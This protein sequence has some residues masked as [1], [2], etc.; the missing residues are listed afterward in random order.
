[1]PVGFNGFRSIPSK[2]R[3][4]G[5][6]V[7][8]TQ[9][10]K[11]SF[12]SRTGEVVFNATALATYLNNGGNADGGYT[13]T[14]YVDNKKLNTKK[15]DARIDNFANTSKL[16][17]TGLRKSQA[18]RKK[19]YCQVDYLPFRGEGKCINAPLNSNV[20]YSV[21]GVVQPR[22]TFDTFDSEEPEI[23]SGIE[24]VFVDI[25][26]ELDITVQPEDQIVASGNT[27]VFDINSDFS[28]Q[29]I[30]Q[31]VSYQWQLGGVDLEDGE[32]E[33]SKLIPV[34]SRPTFTV[35]SD[36]EDSFTIDWSELTS[37]NTFTPGVTY[38]LTPSGDISTRL[39]VIGG[40][41]GASGQKNV[42]GSV[43]G[44]VQ[45]DYTFLKDQTYVLQVGQ[46]G[47]DGSTFDTTEGTIV[48][49]GLPGGGSSTS[50]GERSGGGGGY[51]A[52]FINSVS[53]DNVI[54]IAGGGGGSA[55]DPATGGDGGGLT[56]NDGTSES[57]GTG[58][59]GGDIDGGGA[60]QSVGGIAGDGPT[61][62]PQP[63]AGTELTGGAGY[64][65]GGG[66]AGYFGGGG[67]AAGNVDDQGPGAGGGGAGYGNPT[68]VTDI[69]YEYDVVPEGGTNGSL[70][71][72]LVDTTPLPNPE[73][74]SQKTVV[75]GSKTQQ[76]RITSDTVDFGSTVRCVISSEQAINTPVYSREVNYS[77]VTPKPIID[78]Q[79]IDNTNS[80]VKTIELN[81]DNDNEFYI[82]QGTFGSGY[83]I[84]Q[85][86]SKE[87]DIVARMKMIASS[88]NAFNDNIGGSGG[89]SIVELTLRK[90]V[91]YTIV[92][93]S[94]NSAVYV[95]EKSNL[96]AV[97]GQGGDAGKDGR[98]G[99]GGGV[100]VD[101]SPGVGRG[102][103]TSGGRRPASST[104]TTIGVYGSS[105]QNADITLYPNDTIAGASDGGRTISC[106]KGSY[107]I[108]NGISPCED[109][110]GE[111]I[112]F[113]N[114]SG[115]EVSSTFDLFRGFKT[116]YTITETSGKS[117]P[118]SGKGG[119]GATG[120]NGG[121]SGAGGGGGSGYT[122]DIVD[123]I[124]T[125]AG[126][127]MTQL[128]YVSIGF[129]LSSLPSQPTTTPVTLNTV[130][131]N[132]VENNPYWSSSY[133]MT[134]VSG[135]GPDTLSFGPDSSDKNHNI[136]TGT[137]YEGYYYDTTT[138]SPTI[139]V[140]NDSYLELYR[141][142]TT[143]LT[144]TPNKGRF[145]SDKTTGKLQFIVD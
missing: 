124:E 45:G 9:K 8:F 60:T 129:N 123:I 56:G 119:N 54:I 114:S 108:N 47:S 36:F 25:F 32:I 96:I 66:G 37:Y 115:V 29:V 127:N 58:P 122:N 131:F 31:K 107:W 104:L 6:V 73:E 33:T 136:E 117:S 61:E 144:I 23:T 35:T 5:P 50:L 48:T 125:R 140:I 11:S 67:G 59:N 87:K 100:N 81:L 16:T 44:S 101:G 55:G 74:I 97:V 72:E 91:E 15:D 69:S 102:S 128:S 83:D 34:E 88:G 64:I 142:G 138:V 84:I 46:S 52:L 95:Y 93:V 137:V 76:L 1:M 68:L 49:G 99:D 18:Q 130:T 39:S 89:M 105:M 42:Y 141:Y 90:N 98:G 10:P 43:G 109:N 24:D 70:N 14:W 17:L 71:I 139:E 19:V 145:V 21:S 132:V 7:A 133:S 65:G 92:G 20:T 51:T 13:F 77:V 112:K 75:S 30:D 94:N 103:N 134:K 27:A 116:G 110:S 12:S 3:I 57:G 113:R 80:L 120:G 111:L 26:P 40:G 126:G 78:I 62:Y 41:G 121:V 63:S 85:L 28:S 135:N 82:D 4:N 143:V 2:I 86:H 22:S 106:S 38:T 53:K 79:A 118:N